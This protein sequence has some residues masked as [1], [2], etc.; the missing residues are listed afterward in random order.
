M[1]GRRGGE[2]LV[3]GRQRGRTLVEVGHLS[4]GA[5]VMVP[6]GGGQFRQQDLRQRKTG[7]IHQGVQLCRLDPGKSEAVNSGENIDIK[8]DDN[9]SLF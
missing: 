4:L 3:Q 8:Y 9:K 7:N 1:C 2:G 5:E 6:H